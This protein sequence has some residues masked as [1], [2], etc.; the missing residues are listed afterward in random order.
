MTVAP[1]NPVETGGLRPLGVRDENP[2]GLSFLAL[3]AEDFATHERDLLSQG[4]WA[5]FW[6]RF[7]NWRMGIRPRILRMPFSALY[8]LGAKCCEWF[9]GICLP[10]TVKLGRRVKLEHF[11]G[12][13]LVAESIGDDVI[14]RQNT[15]FGIAR[16][17]GPHDRPRIGNRVDIG[18]GAVIIGGV[19][20]GD[21]AVIGANAV[22]NRDA[23]AGAVMVGIPAR[24]IKTR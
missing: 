18:A 12:M 15:T 16:I 9:G 23:P 8:T 11:G 6:H 1:R 5:V 17:D 3:V 7:G 13:I 14:I 20:I 19:S 24:Q 21:D 10:Y 2:T 4:F 22:V